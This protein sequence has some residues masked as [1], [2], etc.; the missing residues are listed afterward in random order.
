MEQ[1]TQINANYQY[2]DENSGDRYQYYLLYLSLHKNFQ[3]CKW[4]KAL[5]LLMKETKDICIILMLACQ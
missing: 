5:G 2:N 4:A 1:E 3:S